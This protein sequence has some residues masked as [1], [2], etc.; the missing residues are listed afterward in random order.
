MEYKLKWEQSR[1]K[2]QRLIDTF[3]VDKTSKARILKDEHYE[4]SKSSVYQKM[5][6]IKWKKMFLHNI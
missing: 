5:I 6:L 2:T 3:Y 4:K 1:K